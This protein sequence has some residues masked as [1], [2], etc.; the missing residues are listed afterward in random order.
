MKKKESGMITV[1]AITTLIMFIMFF[2]ILL[3]LVNII[4]VQL[5]VQSAITE[6]AKE[7]SAYS[8]ILSKAGYFEFGDEINA[9][10]ETNNGLAELKSNYSTLLNTLGG[11]SQDSDVVTDFNNLIDSL[12]SLEVKD[13]TS[14]GVNYIYDNGSDAVVALMAKLLTKKY[15]EDSNGSLAYLANMGIEGGY[16]ALDFSQSHYPDSSGDTLRITVIYQVEIID[17]PFFEDVGLDKKIVLNASTRV[18]GN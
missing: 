1:E 12:S 4:R 7:I 15:L 9:S 11:E 17:V 8:Y 2:Y 16:D 5:L 3:M 13:F 10:V 6:T 14:V 18:W